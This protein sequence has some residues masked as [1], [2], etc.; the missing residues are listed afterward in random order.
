MYFVRA[1]GGGVFWAAAAFRRGWP[2]KIRP[3]PGGVAE[4]SV[5]K[6]ARSFRLLAFNMPLRGSLCRLCGDANSPMVQN[7]NS[8]Y[9]LQ[10]KQNGRGWDPVL[11]ASHQ[12][13]ILLW[14]NSPFS[15]RRLWA[16][17]THFK[18]ETVRS[19]GRGGTRGSPQRR[20]WPFHSAYAW[21]AHHNDLPPRNT[22]RRWGHLPVREVLQLRVA[23]MQSGDYHMA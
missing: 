19:G 18:F 20:W 17:P 9:D 15:V 2:A 11:V 4:G 5:T 8:L 3:G 14:K 12:W 22:G 21:Y 13:R 6:P 16:P 10:T 23:R 1:R 7:L